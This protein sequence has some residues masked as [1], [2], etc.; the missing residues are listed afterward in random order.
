MGCPVLVL[1]SLALPHRGSRRTL[2]SPTMSGCWTHMQAGTTPSRTVNTMC[3]S[4]GVS[5]H[6]PSP[7]APCTG[8][9]CGNV[10]V[11]QP[12]PSELQN[13]FPSLSKLSPPPPICRREKLLVS[14]LLN[15]ISTGVAMETRNGVGGLHCLRAACRHWSQGQGPEPGEPGQAGGQAVQEAEC[16]ALSFSPEGT[17]AAPVPRAHVPCS[18]P[19]SRPP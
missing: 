18:A 9:P 11:P 7:A 6:P 16:G 19:C 2:V 15:V 13:P 12:P 3:H 14:W 4:G 17:F 10:S 1:M 8:T 5:P